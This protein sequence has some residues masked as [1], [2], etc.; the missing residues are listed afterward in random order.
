MDKCGKGVWVVEDDPSIKE[1]I[2]IILEEE[3]YEI[4]T[5]ENGKG[6]ED[7]LKS[8]P[9]N[10]ILLDILLGE[11]D[12]REICKDL[13]NRYNIPIIL[14]SANNFSDRDIKNSLA[15]KYIKKPFDLGTLVKT[16]KTYAK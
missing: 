13:K 1:A 2:K 11:E 5:F 3:G 7:L 4:V 6:I 12:G 8:D 15:D 16:V 9:P 14:M 10:L